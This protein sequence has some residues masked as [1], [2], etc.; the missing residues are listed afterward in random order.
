MTEVEET[1][2]KKTLGR[3]MLDCKSSIN[4]G[5]LFVIVF[6]PVRAN[7]MVVCSLWTK[8]AGVVLTRS[9]NICGFVCL[10]LGFVFINFTF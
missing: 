5:S 9:P 7:I 1:L 2:E 6:S 3:V 8:G 4:P 10:L